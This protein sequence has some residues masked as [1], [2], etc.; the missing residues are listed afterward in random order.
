MDHHLGG[1]L[2]GRHHPTPPGSAEADAQ[3]LRD[4]LGEVEQRAGSL[5]WARERRWRASTHLGVVGDAVGVDLHDLSVKLALE[6]VDRVAELAPELGCA[7]VVV[8]TGRGARAG[9]VS[10]LRDAVRARLAERA[11]EHGWRVVPEGAG[12]VRLVVDP[13][14]AGHGGL[15]PLFWLVVALLACGLLAAAWGAVRP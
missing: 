14:R 15:G 1:R 4:A 7:S 13:R 11:A 5:P 2:D 12:R 6:A 10:P 9:G 3:R 8:V